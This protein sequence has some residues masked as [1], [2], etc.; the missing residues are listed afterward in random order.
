MNVR[1][2]LMSPENKFAVIFGED[3]SRKFQE[4]AW[5]VNVSAR[6]IEPL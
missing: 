5:G 3:Y 1:F 2:C 4:E 6:D